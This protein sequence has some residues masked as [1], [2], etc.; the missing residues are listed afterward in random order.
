MRTPGKAYSRILSRT[1]NLKTNRGHILKVYEGVKCLITPE[2]VEELWIRDK[3]DKMECPSIDRVD[4]KGHYEKSN[5]RF[6]ELRV[7]SAIHHKNKT[8]DYVGIYYEASRGADRKRKWR[9]GRYRDGKDVRT[10]WCL[11]EKEAVA[12]YKEMFG[13]M[14][15]EISKELSHEPK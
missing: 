6:V 9:G 2:E 10:K 3:A 15:L 11:T 12:E 14:P 4:S 1:V 8:S 7:N 5:C 13:V